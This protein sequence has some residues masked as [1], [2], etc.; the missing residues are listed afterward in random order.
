M[1]CW[2]NE[3]AKNETDC[4]LATHGDSRLRN[5]PIQQFPSSPIY[6]PFH[7][8]NATDKNFGALLMAQPLYGREHKRLSQLGRKNRHAA[9]KPFEILGQSEALVGGG[10]WAGTTLAGDAIEM[11][12]WK[13]VG[14]SSSA[15]PTPGFDPDRD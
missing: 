4:T 13:V 6:P 1:E 14:P 8:P 15:R 7:G 9:H 11:A 3:V 5:P 12:V 2:A 10:A